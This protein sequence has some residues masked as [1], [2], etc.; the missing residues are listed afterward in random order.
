MNAKIKVIDG[1]THKGQAMIKLAQQDK[2]FLIDDIYSNYTPLQNHIFIDLIYKCFAEHGK[3]FHICSFND[4][5][6]TVS[7]QVKN[8]YRLVTTKNSYLVKF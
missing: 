8:G 2:G 7:W 1:N 3:N 5:Q 4:Y 6:Y